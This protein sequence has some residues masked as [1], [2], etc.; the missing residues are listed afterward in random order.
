MKQHL[1]QTAMGRPLNTLLRTVAICAVAALVPAIAPGTA[2]AQEACTSYSVRAGDSL[3]SIAEGAYGTFDYQ[4]IFN[5][6]RNVIFNPNAIEVG[7]VLLLPCADGSLPGT[8]SPQ[9]LIAEQDAEQERRTG[10]AS[11]FEPPIKIVSANGWAPFVGESFDGGGMLVRLATTA[12]NRGGNARDYNVSFVDDWSAHTETLLPLGAFDVSIAWYLPDCTKY[13]M[14]S[15]GMQKRCDELEGSLPIYES[16]VGFF[17]APDNAYA[18]AREYT[19]FAGARV[20]RPAGWFTFDLEEQ[21]LSEPLVTMVVPDAVNDCMEMLTAGE[22]D[23]VPLEI[24]SVSAAAKELGIEGQIV[25]NPYLT[26]LLN[27]HFVTHKTNPRG[28]VYLAL[29]N[30]G[31]TEMRETGEWY[32]I[33][34]SALAEANNL[35]N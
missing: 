32:A 27:M 4:Q 14:L 8:A 13:N 10:P 35:T 15:A 24:E 23:V 18:D 9:E 34:S 33:I 3:A 16:V 5:A 1:T 28:R 21:G 29:L 19:D 6:N 17:T 12:L 31:L 22:V 2:S 20:C 26:N 7:T 25:Q 30:R 11:V